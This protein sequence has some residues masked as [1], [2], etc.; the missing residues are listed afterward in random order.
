MAESFRAVLTSI[1]FCSRDGSR[2]HV[3]VL[4]SANPR[5]GKTTVAS[6]LAIALTEI[7]QRVLLIDGDMRRPRIHEIFDLE[8]KSGLGDLL[9]EPASLDGRPIAEIRE[10]SIP[11]LFVLPAG[12]PAAV[13]SLVYSNRLPELIARVRQ[14][15][16]TILIDTP[17]MLQMA[18]ARVIGRCADAVILVVRANQT[19]R[20]AARMARQRLADDGTHVLGTILNDWNPRHTTSYGYYKYYDHYHHYYGDKHSD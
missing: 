11:N 17:P 4:A 18:D 15:F 13:S 16:D 2:P 12:S 20:D 1:L 19:T 8:N 3:L 10:T 14:D 5:E 7:N 6:N 9:R